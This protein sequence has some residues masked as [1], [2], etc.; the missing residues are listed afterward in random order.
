VTLGAPSG[1]SSHRATRCLWSRH[2]TSCLI[3]GDNEGYLHV[4]DRR[5]TTR[6]LTLAGEERG[7]MSGM[8][9]TDQCS[10]ITSQGTENHLVEWTY[11]KCNLQANS[12]KFKK[13]KREVN[14]NGD[15]SGCGSRS[16]TIQTVPV[17]LNGESTK[18][19][20]VTTASNRRQ[21]ETRF[22]IVS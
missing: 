22:A 13:R 16:A 20:S 8:S 5:R 15:S 14:I 18:K 21:K 4:Y 2:D 7:Q 10:V 1:L 3:V 17:G 19:Q 11:D 12:K 6:L 9:S